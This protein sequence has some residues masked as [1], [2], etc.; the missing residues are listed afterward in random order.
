MTLKI[1]QPTLIPNLVDGL[2]V[3]VSESPVS[4][5]TIADQAMT[6]RRARLRLTNTVISVAAAEDFG[7]VKLVDLPNRN[8]L[9][10]GVEVDCSVVK[11][12]VTN[13]II[14]TTDLDMSIGTAAA[15]STTLASTMINIIEK[16]DIDDNALTVTFAGH[17]NDN[18]TSV[19]PFKIADGASSALY[20]NAV[21]V[22]GI[23]VVAGDTLTVTGTVD[24]Y[25]MD[26]GKE[27]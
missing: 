13:G 8:M 15:S 25:Y 23:T 26:L 7:S 1:K 18:A 2:S 14:A 6:V 12:G 17:S 4:T 19:A 22:G 3:A 9:I 20:M 27:D 24:I 5:I 21:P 10:M 16:K 11:G